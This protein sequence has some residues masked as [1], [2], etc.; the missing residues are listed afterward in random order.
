MRQ[1]D[2]GDN[3]SGG[4]TG[5]AMLTNVHAFETALRA[6]RSGAA[7]EAGAVGQSDQVARDLA[8]I[9]HAIAALRRAEPA[10]ETWNETPVENWSQERP[11]PPMRKARSVW[12]MIGLLWLSTALV[13]VGALA[14]I[15]VLAG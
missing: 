11:M 1:H 15:R 3:V 7:A 10:L 12:L 8:E 6:S 13:T 5:E 4:S 14:A 2:L 9:E